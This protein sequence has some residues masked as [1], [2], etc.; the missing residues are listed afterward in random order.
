MGNQ[1][2]HTATELGLDLSSLLL[3]SRGEKL[4]RRFAVRSP[5]RLP[6]RQLLSLH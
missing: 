1:T 5:R 2:S 3:I 6:P 4:G